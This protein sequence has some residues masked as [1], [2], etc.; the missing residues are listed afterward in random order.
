MKKLLLLVL[1]CVGFQSILAQGKV[2]AQNEKERKAIISEERKAFLKEMLESQSK[3]TVNPESLLSV[4]DVGEP[5][6]FG[7][8]AKFLGTATTGIVYVYYSCDSTVLLADLDLTLGADDRCRLC[9]RSDK[10]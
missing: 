4:T 5:D 3:K 7:K 1:V 8:N 6:S 10:A 2:D 9:R